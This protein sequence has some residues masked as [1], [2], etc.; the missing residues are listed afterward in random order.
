MSETLGPADR[1]DAADLGRGARSVVLVGLMGAGKTTIGRRLAQLLELPFVDTDQEIEDAARMSVAELFAAYGEPEFRALEARVVARL[2][3]GGRQVIATGGGA[4]M[5]EGTRRLLRERSVTVW[6]KADLDTLMERV[7][8]RPTRPLLR[9]ADPRGTLRD[10][11]DK[12][13]PVYAQADLHIHS[14]N[15][16]RDVIAREIIQSLARHDRAKAAS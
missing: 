4:Y 10:L 6:L 5:N 12:R 1:E 15:V 8:K 9:T 7:A 3:E 14:R 2:V 11:M 16:K 13:Y